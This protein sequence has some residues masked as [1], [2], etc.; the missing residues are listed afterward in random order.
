MFKNILATLVTIVVFAP[1]RAQVVHEF[2]IGFSGLRILEPTTP[3]L[4]TQDLDYYWNPQ[5]SYQLHFFDERI[6][7]GL[8]FGWVYAQGLKD[9]ENYNRDDSQKSLNLDFETGVN[10]IHFNNSFLQ[11]TV[12]MRFTK[13]YF[14]SIEIVD[15]REN[16]T[17]FSIKDDQWQDVNLDLTSAIS[18]QFNL[19]DGRYRKSNIA[20]RL[21][22]E[23]VY[24]FP[25]DNELEF[26]EEDY[27]F[28]IGP[29]ASLIWRLRGKKN[30]G[31][32]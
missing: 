30:R 4:F 7:A 18:Y 23:M 21:S 29:S 32:F 3:G 9:E 22:L 24:F 6:V 17:S 19:S 11:W 16:S 15:G 14:Y 1:I 26:L 31:L 13:S 12:G 28:A 25:E 27:R 10:I 2:G 5:L 8:Q 20:L